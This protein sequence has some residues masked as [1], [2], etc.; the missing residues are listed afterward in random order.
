MIDTAAVS[1]FLRRLLGL[2]LSLPT[3]KK[4]VEI[5]PLMI[6]LIVG[7]GFMAHG[8][9]KFFRGPE[10]FAVVLHALGTPNPYLMSVITIVIEIFGGLAILLGAF[11]TLA[12]IP[13]IIVLL[14]ATFTVHLQ[15][16]F[17]SIKILAITPAGA[18]FGP[19][20]YETDLLYLAGLLALVIGGPGR[21]AVDTLLRKRLISKSN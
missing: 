18:Q 8:F 19:P 21:F 12:S 20:G 6:R 4:I 3:Q 11:I 17:S 14:V 13:M 2:T 7:Y 10:S 5:A 15:Y 9:A 16:G 1:S